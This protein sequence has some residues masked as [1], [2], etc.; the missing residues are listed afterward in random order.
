LF[1]IGDYVI[2]G[3]TGACR[4]TGITERPIRGGGSRRYY[5][6]QPLY[7]SCQIY[8]PVDSD[9]VF[10]RP[11]ISRAEAERL[12]DSIPSVQ[13]EAV[14]SRVLRD[15]VERYEASL[16]SHACGDLVELTMSIYAKKRVAAESGRKIGTVDATFMKRAEDLLFGELAVALDIPRE[17]VPG[18]I[19]SRIGGKTK[20]S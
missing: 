18:Y 16:R 12:I 13:A 2:Y 19:A 6:I 7:Q 10:M 15:L 20:Q 3:G 17:T 11:V 5:Q 8:A 9:K 14:Q 1:Q 4:I